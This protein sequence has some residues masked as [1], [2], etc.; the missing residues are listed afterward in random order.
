MARANT[1][2]AAS[3]VK[4]DGGGG[5]GAADPWH[6]P[7]SIAQEDWIEI[8]IL[9]GFDLRYV[10]IV[11]DGVEK[12]GFLLAGTWHRGPHHARIDK[13]RARRAVP[14]GV[15]SSPVSIA[16]DTLSRA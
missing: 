2:R 9:V 1:H 16:S 11:L 13:L 10:R 5:R 6:H 8:G 3:G 14:R 7:Y 12:F 15:L 4:A